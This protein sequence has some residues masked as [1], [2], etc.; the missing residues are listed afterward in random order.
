VLIA[1][2]R[3]RLEDLATDLRRRHNRLTVS[4]HLTASPRQPVR[5]S[6]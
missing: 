2:N 5:R 4:V 1:R 3:Q 6:W